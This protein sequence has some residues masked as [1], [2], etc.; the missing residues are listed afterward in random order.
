MLLRDDVVLTWTLLSSHSKPQKSLAGECHHGMLRSLTA[1]DVIIVGM[2]N[3]HFA[4]GNQRHT[5]PPCTHHT[6]SHSPHTRRRPPQPGGDSSKTS[7]TFFGEGQDN[8]TGIQTQAPMM[9][10]VLQEQKRKQ[11][12]LQHAPACLVPRQQNNVQGSSTTELGS[13]H[14]GI[15]EYSARPLLKQ[16]QLA[17]TMHTALVW[18]HTQA[19]RTPHYIS[20]VS[21]ARVPCTSSTRTDPKPAAIC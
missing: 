20:S 7:S 12:T 9:A 5:K 1:C 11:Y 14:S 13:H 4:A 19:D 18:G 15:E 17:T 2:P 16:Q 8:N 21:R 3:N 10:C 6:H